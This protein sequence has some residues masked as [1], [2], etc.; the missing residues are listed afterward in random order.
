MGMRMMRVD[1]R[2]PI[3]VAL[4]KVE[5]IVARMCL[6]PPSAS[7]IMVDRLPGSCAELDD[8]KKF[9]FSEIL[10]WLS[11]LSSSQQK[12]PN[13]RKTTTI[14]IPRYAALDAQISP[15]NDVATRKFH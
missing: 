9:K 10:G 4:L 8:N 11:A 12:D 14:F 5:C 7:R 15:I 1:N 6:D 13:I 3:L 2:Y